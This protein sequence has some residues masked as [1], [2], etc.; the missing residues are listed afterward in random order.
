LRELEES[1][2]H[3][4]FLQ[5]RDVRADHHFAALR[6]ER[7]RALERRELAIDLPIRR[8]GRLARGGV[9]PHVGGRDLRSTPA[10]EVGEQVQLDPSAQSGDRLPLFTS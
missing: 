2:P 4:A 9:A 3:V 10:A 1:S 7:V 5:H 8:V 6:S